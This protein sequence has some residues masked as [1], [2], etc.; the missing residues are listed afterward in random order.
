MMRLEVVRL[1]EKTV[2]GVMR[3]GGSE[4]KR[5]DSVR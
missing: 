2:L 1:G 3:I 5:L 4:V